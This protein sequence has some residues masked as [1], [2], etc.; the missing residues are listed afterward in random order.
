MHRA[1]RSLQQLSYLF[2]GKRNDFVPQLSLI[3]LPPLDHPVTTSATPSV[4]NCVRAVHLNYFS[5]VA[6]PNLLR[7]IVNLVQVISVL[8]KGYV[9]RPVELLRPNGAGPRTQGLQVRL[10]WAK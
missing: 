3:P 6:L 9:G 4:E 2:A 10:H 1:T 7:T 5:R 8:Q